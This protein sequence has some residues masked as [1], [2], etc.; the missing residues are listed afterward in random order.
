MLATEI[1]LVVREVATKKKTPEVDCSPPREISS[2]PIFTLV[3][4]EKR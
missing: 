3:L 2:L 4:H 1:Y